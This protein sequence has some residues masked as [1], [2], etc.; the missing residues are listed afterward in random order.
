MIHA[1]SDRA[2][3]AF[4]AFNCSGLPRDT[5][6]S[7]LFGHRHGSFTDAHEDAPGIIRGAAGGTLMLDEIGELDPSIQPKLLRFLDSGEVQPVG[8]PRPVPTDVR[9]IAANNVAID[10]LV[11]ERR[12]REDLFYR[13]NVVRL[14]IPPLRERREEIPPL[15][16]HFLRRYGRE[17]NRGGLKLSSDAQTCLL[18]YD[19]PGNVRQ[20]ANEIRS[21]VAMAQPDD[22]ITPYQLSPEVRAASG[23]GRSGRREACAE[24]PG[25]ARA[26]DRPAAVDGR[27]AGGA[28]DDP[29]GDLEG[30]QPCE[31]GGKAARSVAEGALPEAAPPGHRRRG[32]PLDSWNSVHRD[33]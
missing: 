19:W 12:F 9:I 8:E 20:L 30:G 2:A 21:F 27:R 29:L 28:R 10:T 23:P 25:R 7:Q 1:A 17:M 32:S 18:V 14:R 5:A 22:T 31:H 26:P 6:D 13:L 3:Q 11:R 16:R 15:V 4:V 24:G 33:N